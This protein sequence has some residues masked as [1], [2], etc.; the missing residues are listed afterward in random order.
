MT[1]ATLLRLR[2]TAEVNNLTGPLLSL[3]HNNDKIAAVCAA[4]G[5][6]LKR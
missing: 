5:L 3:T 2:E 1:W 6:V 4:L